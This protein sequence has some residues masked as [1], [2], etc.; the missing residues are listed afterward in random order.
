MKPFT[1]VGLALAAALLVLAVMNARSKPAE[2]TRPP[3]ASQDAQRPRTFHPPPRSGDPNA[4][5]SPTTRRAFAARRVRSAGGTVG[6]AQTTGALPT[7]QPQPDPNAE[8]DEEMEPVVPLE[9][10]RVAL[11]F[12]GQDPDA[13]DAWVE[14]INDPALSPEDRQNLIEDLNEEGF[15]DPKNITPDDLPLILSR[16]ELIEEL[17]PQAM[18][19]VNADAFAEAYKDLTNMLEK[20]DVQLR[21]EEEEQ[22]RVAA[23]AAESNPSVDT[24]SVHQRY[25]RRVSARR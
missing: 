24:W 13:E 9:V 1:V 2:T 14:A 16:I 5:G 7:G 21:A 15:P 10:A 20:I 4:S 11:S 22:A 18:D 25:T 23:A 17:G 12:V 19:E 8:E 6:P 3:V